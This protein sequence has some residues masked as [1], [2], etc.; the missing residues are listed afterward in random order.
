MA[1]LDYEKV[2]RQERVNFAP[3]WRSQPPTFKQID[4]IKGLAAQKGVRV[5]LPKTKQGASDLIERLLAMEEKSFWERLAPETIEAKDEPEP[6]ER[7]L[8]A[9]EIREAFPSLVSP[10]TARSFIQLAEQVDALG[11]Y[12]LMDRITD[13]PPQF[14]SAEEVVTYLL[15]RF[16]EWARTD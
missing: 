4:Y 2:K 6:S 1:K 12:F 13:N 10:M 8:L 7:D 16:Y 11:L 5:R 9:E 15:S 3:S 14:E